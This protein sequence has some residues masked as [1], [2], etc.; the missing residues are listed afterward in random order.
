MTVAS[1]ETCAVIV[2]YR[3]DTA[4]LRSALQA[5]R[6]QA[7][8]VFV[9]DNA[10]APEAFDGMTDALQGVE[11]QRSAT[12]IGLA[13]AFNRGIDFAR[14]RGFRFVLLLDQDSVPGPGMVATL[15]D[16][17]DA[18]SQLQ[19]VAA[20]GAVPVDARNG[21]PAP[22]VRVGFPFNRK[23]AA[24][25]RPVGCD[26]LISSGSLI[27]LEALAAIGGMEEGLFIDNV[28]LDWCFRARARGLALFGVGAARMRHSIGDALRPS[29]LQRG[30]AFV[31]QPVRLYYIMR[32]RVLLYRRRTTP[33][34]WIAQDLLRLP[35]K[36]AATLLFQRPRR[37]YLER[38]LS[39]LRD[40]LRGVDG[41]APPARRAR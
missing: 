29:R 7:G 34:A 37:D 1:R 38:M 21:L 12:N 6:E 10:S 15:R 25:D 40:G 27:P 3:P 20:V 9:F 39:G 26:F 41:P 11:L 17:F 30:G 18:V 19:P 28:D 14:Q 4:I 13:A 5:C 16:A 36:F 2:T 35:L 22:F 23:L 32:N 24:S 8:A 31:H 33:R